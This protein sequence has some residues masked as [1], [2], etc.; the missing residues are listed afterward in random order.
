MERGRKEE[1]EGGG[2][3]LRTSD[4]LSTASAQAFLNRVSER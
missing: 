4:T 1:G 2:G 3:L